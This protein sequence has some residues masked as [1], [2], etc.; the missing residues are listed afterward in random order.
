M[1]YGLKVCSCHPLIADCTNSNIVQFTHGGSF[2]D[3]TLVPFRPLRIALMPNGLIAASNWT[4]NQVCMIDLTSKQVVKTLEIHNACAICYHEQSD[5][6]LVGRCLSRD[7]EGN[8]NRESG[9]IEQYCP[10]TGRMVARISEPDSRNF[11]GT[12]YSPSSP[13]DMVLTNESKLIAADEW[14][15]RVY[16]ISC[17][18][19]N[20]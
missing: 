12:T 14:V 9:V 19:S 15:V 3:I 17:S 4:D 18:N 6:M 1:A 8:P 10:T 11:D 7:K 20:T 2:V 16:D 13:Q 5:S